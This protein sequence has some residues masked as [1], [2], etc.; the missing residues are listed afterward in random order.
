MLMAES[1]L[2]FDGVWRRNG[3]KRSSS[4]GAEREGNFPLM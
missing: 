1:L 2:R 4:L 3:K